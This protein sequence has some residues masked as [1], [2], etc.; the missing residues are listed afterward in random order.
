VTDSCFLAVDQSQFDILQPETAAWSNGVWTMQL[1]LA[2][3][4]LDNVAIFG[5]S[6]GTAVGFVY[7]IM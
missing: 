1:F 7:V 3:R 5:Y 6:S 4:D 2:A